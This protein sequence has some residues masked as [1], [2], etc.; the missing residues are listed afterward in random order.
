MT[1]YTVIVSPSGGFNP[2]SLS[3][4]TDSDTVT[5]QNNSSSSQLTISSFSSTKWSSSS[6]LSINPQGGTGSKTV[7]SGV[8]TGSDGVNAS[9]SGGGGGSFTAN[10][11]SSAPPPVP[12]TPSPA[13]NVIANNVY[14]AWNNTGAASYDLETEY[15]AG[16]S[17]TWTGLSF[18]NQTGLSKTWPGLSQGNRRFR[19][20]SVGSNGLKSNYTSWSSVVSNIQETTPNNFIGLNLSALDPNNGW[21]YRSNTVSGINVPIPISV[22]SGDGQFS[23]NG[24][25]TYVTS[26]TVSN[27]DTVNFRLLTPLTYSTPVSS[28][29]TAGGKT[30]TIALSTKNPTTQPYGFSISQV[31]NAEPNTT[32]IESFFVDGTS[33]GVNVSVSAI[34]GSATFSTTKFGTYSSSISVQS[35]QTVYV[36]TASL[37]FGGTRNITVSANGVTANWVVSTRNAI[38]TPNPFDSLNNFTN[39]ELLAYKYRNFTL[40]GVETAIIVSASGSGQI[41]NNGVS[42]G[43]TASISNGGTVYCRV[44]ASGSYGTPTS[45]TFSATGTSTSFSVNTRDAN[46]TPV[47]FSSL[48]NY[49]NA[50][51]NNFY[52]RTFQVSGIET[53]ITISASN[54][55]V[56]NNNVNWYT[57][58]SF[59]NGQTVYCRIQASGSYS[60]TVFSTF[61][62]NVSGGTSTSFSVHTGTAPDTTPENFNPSDQDNLSLSA[63]YLTPIVNIGTINETVNVNCIAGTTVSVA[64]QNFTSNTTISNGQSFIFKTLTAS[65]NSTPVT[66][67]A[68]IG[69]VYQTWILTTQAVGIVYISTPAG[70]GFN[71]VDVLNFYGASVADLPNLYRGG[72]FVPNIAANINIPTSGT[73]MLRDFENCAK[74]TV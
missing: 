43:S 22:T 65:V 20:R 46:T 13:V 73:M 2:S 16:N 23:I 53:S 35:P 11:I 62:H 44:R 17:G 69:T 12:N 27:G 25:S 39:S 9:F 66:A 74:L 32:Q 47:P 15:R 33:T 18:L 6:N 50:A 38:T 19:V 64:G 56:S 48:T 3:G 34:V 54:G 1:A 71:L 5:F 4:L 63:D 45:G 58:R 28:T 8:S 61:Y 29:F 36:K 37:G 40:T 70:N 49:Y 55:W 21:K 10:F 57:S 7:K 42:W 41:S 51:I 67:G 31:D 52:I 24:S 68:T 59:T 60:A 30:C 72:S 14:V 26:G